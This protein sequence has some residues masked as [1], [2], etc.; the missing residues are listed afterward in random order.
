M[1][2]R[3]RFLNGNVAHRTF[4]YFL[5]RG[6]IGNPFTFP[7][8]VGICNTLLTRRS[9]L[10]RQVSHGTL[11]LRV[12]ARRIIVG[13]FTPCRRR[14]PSVELPLSLIQFDDTGSSRQ[15]TVSICAGHSPVA[16]GNAFIYPDI[17]V[18]MVV[19]YKCSITSFISTNEAN[20][21]EFMQEEATPPS[22]LL[23]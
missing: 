20:I 5:A 15:R 6:D 8:I 17:I 3:K 1:V 12:Q 10:G 7:F 13:C 19:P 4:L 11:L 18:I 14:N 22:L 2:C 21:P 16:K 9:L 23:P